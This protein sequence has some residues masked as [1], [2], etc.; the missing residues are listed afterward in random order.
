M[1]A[2]PTTYTRIVLAERPVGDIVPSKTFRILADE[3]L[4]DL[5]PGERQVLVAVDY[6]SL[7]PAMR[8]WLGEKRTYLPPVALGETMRAEGL[9]TVVKAGKGSQ[10]RTG[11]TVK[12]VFGWTEYARMNDKDV[13]LRE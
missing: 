2:L 13:G 6:L 9:G 4:A 11:Q 12:G 8:S 10:W 1:P 7:D 3:R 5:E